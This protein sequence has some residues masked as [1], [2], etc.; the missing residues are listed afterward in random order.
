MKIS[1]SRSAGSSMATVERIISN[2]GDARLIEREG[3]NKSKADILFRFG[4]VRTHRSSFEINTPTMIR[5]MNNKPL[6]RRLLQEGHVRIPLTY[7]S[8][9]EVERSRHARFPLIGRGQYH[10]QGKGVVICNNLRDVNRD[11]KSRY[12]SEIIDKDREYRVYVFFGKVVGMEEKVPKDRNKVVWNYH[13]G[14]SVFESI[15][16]KNYPLSVCKLAV[17]AAECIGVDFSAVDLISKDDDHYV[18]ELN[19]SPSCSKSKC[20]RIAQALC[21]AKEKIEKDGKKPKHLTLPNTIKSYKDIM[22][23]VCMKEE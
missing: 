12:W 9:A 14:N 10:L 5:T 11:M 6:T 18:L 4:G 22:H 1:I 23:P 17:Q 21:W 19:A 15:K 20:R 7:F 3:M 13:A 16:W 8:K 2:I